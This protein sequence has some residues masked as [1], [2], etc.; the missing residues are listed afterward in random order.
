MMGAQL[1]HGE[2]QHA[3][4]TAPLLQRRLMLMSHLESCSSPVLRVRLNPTFP[5]R[6]SFSSSYL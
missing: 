3:G 4:N 2:Y 1:S 5:L 6:G